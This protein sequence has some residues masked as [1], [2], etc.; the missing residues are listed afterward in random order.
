MARPD[1]ETGDWRAGLLTGVM[2]RIFR[3]LFAFVHFGDP[4]AQSVKGFVPTPPDVVD[5]MVAKLFAGRAP[6]AVSRVLDP[7]CGDGEFIAGVL[8]ACAENPWPTP[9]IVGVELD[10]SRAAAARRRFSGVRGVTI[11]ERDFLQPAAREFDFI[12][13]NPPYV[14]ILGLSEGERHEYRAAYRTA[15]G[16]FDLYALFFEQAL[17]VAE[18][19]ARIVFITPEKFLYVQTAEPLRELLRAESVEELCFTSEAT[20]ARRVTY[21][22]I[23]TVTTGTRGGRTR[24]QRRAGTESSVRLPRAGTW[25]PAVEGFAAAPSHVRLGD[26]A[27][28]IS[29]GVATGADS[30]YVMPT[31]DIPDVL[32]RFSHPTVSGRQILPSRRVVL[33][34]SLLAP[35]NASGQLLRESA[36]GALGEFLRDPVRLQRLTART[37]TSR[38]PWYAYHDNLPLPDVLRPKLLCK[39]ITAQPFFV[40]D[41][42]GTLVPRHSVYYIVPTDATLLEPLSEYL[43]SD[44]V[45]RW[46]RA[47]CQR[48]ANGYLRMQSHVLKELPLPAEFSSWVAPVRSGSPLLELVSA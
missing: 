41:R 14:S 17:R 18:P 42:V 25:L 39:D 36:L 40:M 19:G 27:L 47:H 1:R 7:G 2:W 5:L 48:A 3:F 15:R 43:N 24:V 30:V 29:C 23:T 16:R 33:E 35:Y 46:L 37:C 38:K 13:G 10:R 44:E 21:P 28:R 32:R 8:R 4:L 26:I 9:Q 12:I 34:S 22:L 11:A 20:F 6:S 45:A 31:A